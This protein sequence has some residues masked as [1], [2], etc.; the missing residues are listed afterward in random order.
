MQ[1][2][3][4]SVCF[5]FLFH[6][7]FSETC[8][9]TCSYFHCRGS[10][11]NEIRIGE[12]WHEEQADNG[13]GCC[14]LW[15]GT[16]SLCCRGHEAEIVALA[17]AILDPDLEEDVSVAKN[18]SFGS[19]SYSSKTIQTYGVILCMVVIT[20]AASSYWIWRFYFRKM[21]LTLEEPE[22]IDIKEFDVHSALHAEKVSSSYTFPTC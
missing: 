2:A 17:D 4:R 15:L 1:R 18:S 16:C 3:F 7:A 22:E 10:F 21:E 6:F 20:C 5:L 19:K 11:L 12:S 8:K 14:F 13:K 9:R